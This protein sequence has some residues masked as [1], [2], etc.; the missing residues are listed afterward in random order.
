MESARK[1]D[2]TVLVIFGAKGDLTMRKLAPALYNL[3]LD[4]WLPEQFAVV[5]VSHH[6]ISEEGFRQ[7]LYDGVNQFSRNGKVAEERWQSF[8]S[9]ICYFKADFT[10]AGAYS[11]LAK[12]LDNYDL[13]WGK[14]AN[15]VFYLSVAPQFIEPITLNIGASGIATNSSRDRIVVEKPFGRDLESAKALNQLLSRTFSECQIYRIDHYLGKETVQN[16]LAFRFANALFEPIWNRNYIDYV[17]ITVAE[18]VGVEHRGNYYDKSGALRDMIQNHILQLLC[19]IAMEPPVT[20][21]ADEIRSKKVDVLHALRKFS[22]DEMHKHAVRGQ[23]GPGWIEGRKVQGYR[24]EP[25]VHPQSNT[26]TYAAV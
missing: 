10:N 2:A 4:G 18:Q 11:D 17:Q 25:G 19:M 24:E 15:R 3:S 22:K 16:I 9:S 6:N 12:E 20:F 8:I 13:K 14:R 1:P 26:E 7:L 23:Y 21:D 5:G